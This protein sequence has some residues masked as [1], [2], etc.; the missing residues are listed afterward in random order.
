MSATNEK[1]DDSVTTSTV[2]SQGD[3]PTADHVDDINVV[4]SVHV[5]GT[6]DLLDRRAIGGDLDEMPR[7]YF[8]SAHFLGTVAGVTLGNMS[9]NLGW[10]MP[11][12]TLAIM[13]AAIGPS[14]N[15]N[16][17]A[18]AWTLSYG[19]GVLLYGRLTDIFG[20]K[21]ITVG[22]NLLCLIGCVV[23]G[24]AQKV[25]ALIGANICTGLA[26]SAQLSSP[27]IL[28]EI[29]P[30]RQRGPIIAFVFFCMTPF[31]VFG[32]LIARLFVLHTS[33]G[34]R[35]SYYLGIIISGL[36]TL[37]LTVFYKPPRYEQL[38]VHGKSPWQQ[39]RELDWGGLFLYTAGL[40]LF[41]VGLSWGGQVYPWKSVKVICTIVVGGL[42][43][44]ALG[45][46]EQYGVKGHGVLMPPRLFKNLGFVALTM[47]SAIGAMVYFSM[48]VLWPT[49][50]GAVF[51]TESIVIG[52]QSCVV[53]GGT[54]LGQVMSGVSLTHVPKVKWQAI[55]ASTCAAVFFAS[56]ASISPQR[57]AS[58][59]A[60]GVLACFNVGF[61]DNIGFAG[62]SL[63][64]EPQ[65]IGLACG[66]LGSI[67][68]IGG[69]VAQ[70]LYSSIMSTKVA[71]YLPAYVGPAVLE[72][73]LPESSLVP[74]LQ[75]LATGNLT[76]VP[77]L[78]PEIIAT[79]TEEAKR[80]YAN[81]FRIVFYSTIPFGVILTCFSFFVPNMDK[82]LHQNVARKLQF[83]AD[84]K[85]STI[86]VS[87]KPETSV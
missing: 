46:Y 80:A 69:A 41:L 68:T 67:R 52:W 29:V 31:A 14:P 37:L 82:Y 15:I 3:S 50:I 47:T 87:R 38:H 81:S 60:L 84:R 45:F 63:L 8:L 22:L 23:G 20:R 1:R 33:A 18:T 6:V 16:W 74:L 21:W 5:D 64:F 2:A 73:G 26:A 11:A 83:S 10:V 39:A 76:G 17:V 55:T 79:A 9:A 12:N 24:T 70:A 32:P 54:L 71:S 30:N 75:G 35:W 51:T 53:G 4:K 66:V 62:V 19:L 49:I 43:L 61:I 59:I 28:G 77:G 44:V 78:T 86:E 65:D 48:T 58:T 13:N 40:V 57:H 27:T 85:D 36:A 7:G 42:T 25:E 72:A 56:L 34:W